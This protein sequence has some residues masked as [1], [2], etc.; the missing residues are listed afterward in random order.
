MHM[1]VSHII[2]KLTVLHRNPWSVLQIRDH[3]I[4]NCQMTVRFDSKF[5]IIA[6]LFDSIQNEKKHYLHSTNSYIK[7]KCCV[8]SPEWS[9]FSLPSIYVYLDVKLEIARAMSRDTSFSMMSTGTN[10]AQLKPGHV[11]WWVWP[12]VIF[13][14]KYLPTP[15][16]IQ[17]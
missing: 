15:I 6:Q 3:K 1:V 9:W 11:I 8:T 16:I 17:L 14:V 7:L 10:M 13:T 5:Q 4:D 12:S 2:F